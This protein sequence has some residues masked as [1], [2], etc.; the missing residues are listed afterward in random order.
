MRNCELCR[1]GDPS[2]TV[3]CCNCRTT[4]HVHKRQLDKVPEGSIVLGDCPGCGTTN[5]WQKTRGK[6]TYSGPVSYNGQKILDLRVK[7]GAVY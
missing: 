7:N 5:C 6:I 4:F 3:R 2:F 1:Q